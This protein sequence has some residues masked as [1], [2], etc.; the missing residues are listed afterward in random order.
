MTLS[1]VTTVIGLL[2]Q[3]SSVDLGGL[4]RFVCGLAVLPVAITAV[5]LI[6]STIRKMRL[7]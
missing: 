1:L 2:T 3:T 6:I 5:A 4:R 7:G